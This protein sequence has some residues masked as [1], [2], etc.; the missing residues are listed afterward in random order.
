MTVD[1]IAQVA[2]IERQIFSIP[3]S[4]KAFRDSM[5]SD[6]TIYIVAKEND[7]VA[8]YAGMYLSFEEGNITNVAVNPL[9]RRKG[10]GEKIVRDILNRAYEKGVR[11][12]FL[13]VRETNSVAIALYEKIG[14]KEEGIRKNFYDKPRENALIMWKHNL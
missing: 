1:D 13:E 5:E 4:E 14:F 11:D 3:W 2:E 10:I 6:N 8:G 9:S 7:N 12:V